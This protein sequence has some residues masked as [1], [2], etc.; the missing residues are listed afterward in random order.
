M[1]VD[2]SQLEAELG[3]QCHVLSSRGLAVRDLVTG[4]R[5][6]EAEVEARRP[7]SDVPLGL[8]FVGSALPVPQPCPS[9]GHVY[10][11]QMMSTLNRT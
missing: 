2:P 5:A 10:A 6:T 8:G 9:L 1:S 11:R 3:R 7:A 4:S